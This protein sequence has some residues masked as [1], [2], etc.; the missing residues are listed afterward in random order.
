[1]KRK[2]PVTQSQKLRG[3]IYTRWQWSRDRMDGVDAETFYQ[4]EMQKI[5][6]QQKS[7]LEPSIDTL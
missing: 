3:V 1:M 5:I 2:Q 7:L 6:H 4:K